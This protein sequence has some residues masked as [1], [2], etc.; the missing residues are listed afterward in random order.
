[1]VLCCI[2]LEIEL[3]SVGLTCGFQFQDRGCILD[4]SPKEAVWS[5]KILCEG[6]TCRVTCAVAVGGG[7]GVVA[8]ELG[9]SL[10]CRGL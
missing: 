10:S 7:S 4:T 1:M 9:C 3:L 8:H 2:A 5:G 6:H